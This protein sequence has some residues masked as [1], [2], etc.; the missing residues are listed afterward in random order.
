MKNLLTLSLISLFLVNV[1]LAAGRFPLGPDL[2]E[3][4]GVVCTTPTEHRYPENIDYCARDVDSYLKKSIIAKYDTMF[5]YS[6]RSMNR[7]DFKIDHL[8]PLCAGGANDERNLWPQHKSVYEIT[9]P[10]EPLLCEKMAEGKLKQADAIKLIMRAKL[11]LQE[12][13]AVLK[14]L[15]RM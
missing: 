11:N 2:K 15:Q 10:I 3:T 14:E 8:I 1:A 5:G 6:I 4:P 12:A 13:P 7:M 9:D